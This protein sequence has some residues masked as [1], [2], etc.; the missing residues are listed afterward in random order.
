MT[1]SPTTMAAVRASGAVPNAEY[2]LS[3]EGVRKEFPGVVALDDVEFKLKRGTVHALMGENGAGKS[4]LMKI[5]AGIYQPDQGEV[6]L[7]GVDIRLKSP[8]D[9][10]ENGIAMIHQ[11]L[12]LMPFMTVAENIWIRREP[13]N[14]FGLVDHGEMRRMTAKLFE[15]LKI[16]LDPEIEVRHLSVANRQMVEIAKAVSYESDVLIMDEPTSALTERE[17]AH[18]FEIIRDLRSQGIG[19]VY[20][21]HKMNELFEI[22]DEFSVFRDGKYI[23]THASSNVTRDDII[24]MMVGR[25]ITQMFPKEEVPIGD[26]VLSVKNLTLDEVFREVS[27][28]VR[29][30]EILGVAGLVGSGRSNVAETLFGVTPASSGMIA[31][32]G[33]AVVIDNPNT[34][35]RHRMAFLTEDRKDT[36]CLL[37]LDILENMQIAVLQD[38][39]VKRGFVSERA[40]AAACEEMS[41]KLRVKTPNLQERIEN[42]SGGNQQKV[43]IGRWLLTN[44]RILILDEPTRG[45]DVG[46]KAEIHRLVTELARNGVAVIMISSE[47]PEVLGMSDRIMVMHEGRVTGFLDRA[48]AT[49]IKVM[50]LAAR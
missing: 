29:A 1:L 43:L 9:A 20:I 45:I 37:I 3:A 19:I 22:A 40:I 27:F 7:K 35:I 31:I 6:K 48:E 4:T 10:L 26:V 8:L 11:E 41:R 34:A 50:E 24:R 36:G 12:N 30:G 49:Q 33:K 13:K 21:T 38:K 32:D 15:R 17:V 46:A 16:N 14:R 39:F 5:L 18:L 2:L 23:G 28:D 44:P 42:L 47:M 25:E